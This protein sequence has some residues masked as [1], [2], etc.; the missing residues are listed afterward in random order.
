M[1][2]TKKALAS[3]AIA[4]MVLSMAPMNVF[5][6][7]TVTTRLAG[8]DR[9]ATAIAVAGQGWTSSDN[10]IVVPADD[11]N[12]VDALAAAPLAGQ[13]NAPI[14]VTYKGALDPTVQ[15]KIV[16]LK[17]KNVYAIGALSADAV[18]SLKAISG[19]TV[20]ALQGA[21]RT[22]TAAKVA[23]QLT[24]IKGSFVVAYN[25]TPDAMSAAS[26]AAANGYSILVEN[27]DGT[28]PANEAAYNVGTKYT[29]GG[30]ATMTGVT[31]LAGADRY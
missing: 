28:L 21:D 24:N 13:L 6:A 8:S 17:A 11:A 7:T 5:G 26:F 23:A 4:G 27:P 3:L 29:V 2:K 19:V 20:T 31:S 15:Q 9:I 10:V 25:G 18:S 12:I 16:D 14:L 30:Q 22:E 1:R